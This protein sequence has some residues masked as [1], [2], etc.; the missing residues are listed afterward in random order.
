M[1]APYRNETDALRERKA[2]LEQ[3][4]ARLREQT[5]Q[6]D[7]LRAAEAAMA[8]EVADIDRKLG[9]RRALPMLD[10]VKVAS[11]CSASWDDMVGDARVRFCLSCEKNVFNLSAMPRAEA[12]ALLQERTNGAELCVRYYQR[13]DGTLMTADCPVGAKRKRRK[14]LALAVAGAGALAA[15]ATTLLAS[16][17]CRVTQGTLEITRTAEVPPPEPPAVVMGGL[18]PMPEPS[19]IPEPPPPPPTHKLGRLQTHPSE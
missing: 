12:E 2:T 18:M 8:R 13:S 14:K 10:Q 5:T 17:Q 16:S 4:L 15:A 7:A 3:E 9:G 1:S 19:A 11:P 6:L